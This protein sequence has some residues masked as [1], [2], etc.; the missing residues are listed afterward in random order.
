MIALTKALARELAPHGICVNSVAPG[1]I[2]A[3]ML[4]SE[5]AYSEEWLAAHVPIG[6]FGR[7][8][9]GGRLRG[10][11][12]PART[13]A[14]SS[15]RS[16]RRT[17]GRSSEPEEPESNPVFGL[18]RRGFDHIPEDE[19]TMTLRETAYFWVGTNANLFFVAVGVI[20]SSSASAL[21]GARRRRARHVAV[22][23]GRR[24]VDRRRPFR[25]A[26]DDLH[27]RRLR[28]AR[29]PPERRPH[30]GGLV[31]F[32]AINCIFG[33]YALLASMPT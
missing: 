33:V 19:R 14:I 25:A 16:S 17:G 32:V 5:A 31:A 18:E 8:E 23:R 22:R 21:A 12:W 29:Q 1:P 20:A 10:A 30:L 6:R 24:R 28:A 27:P 7:P 11:S 2:E 3:G 4:L 13:A 15:A 26:D 9:R